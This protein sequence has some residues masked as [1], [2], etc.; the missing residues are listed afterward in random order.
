MLYFPKYRYLFEL[1]E[2]DDACRKAHQTGAFY[3]FHNLAPLLQPSEHQHLPPKLRLLGKPG[4]SPQSRPAC[5]STQNSV[6]SES[7]R[8]I[9]Q[10]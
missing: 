10:V 9:L 3:L 4:V 5:A 8:R 7:L 1:K 6:H 2:D